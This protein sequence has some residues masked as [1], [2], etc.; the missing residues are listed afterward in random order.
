MLIVAFGRLNDNQFEL[1]TEAFSNLG[2][3][4]L[5]S[6]SSAWVFEGVLLGLNGELYTRKCPPAA[7]IAKKL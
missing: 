2:A 5:T 7:A 4:Y 3:M 6:A 1:V